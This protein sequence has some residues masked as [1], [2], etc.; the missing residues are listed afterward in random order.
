MRLQLIVGIIL[1]V[2]GCNTTSDGTSTG[3]PVTINISSYSSTLS[4]GSGSSKLQALSGVGTQAVSDLRFC[5][6]RLRFKPL[7][8]T[9]A[10][11]PS[12]D[13]DN[14]D[15]LLG[16]VRISDLGTSLGQVNIPSGTYSRVEFDL[17]DS[18]SGFS[19]RVINSSGTF[20]TSDRITIKFQGTL[21]VS[22]GVTLDLNIQSI[23][24][25]LNTV[26]NSNQVRSKAEGASG[27]F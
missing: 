13:S 18:C 6:K 21:V 14:V 26:T 20:Q 16:E 22:G 3:N 8:S 11:D 10:S 2:T 7:G 15:L 9:T 23:V 12:T 5:F 1:A 25:A 4:Q 17:E 27:S 19:A 24:S